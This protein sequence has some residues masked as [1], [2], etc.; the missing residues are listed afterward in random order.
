MGFAKRIMIVEDD[1]ALGKVLTD[2]F[3]KHGYEI[4]LAR[5]SI[6]AHSWLDGRVSIILLDI[7]LPGRKNGL[8]ILEEIRSAEQ[9]YCRMPVIML[10]NQ[11]DRS[12]EEKAYSLGADDFL[13]KSNSSLD[14]IMSVIIEKIEQNIAKVQKDR[15]LFLSSNASRIMDKIVSRLPST[16]DKL[17]MAFIPTGADPYD[18]KP[19]LEQDKTALKKAG[20][21][22]F[23]L[24]LKEKDIPS[25]KESLS[26]IDIIF[27]AGGDV[28]YLMKAIQD[29]GL[30]EIIKFFIRRE[31]III[32]SSAGS[33]VLG[34]SINPYSVFN[35][36]H[37]VKLDNTDG[38]G[39]I[40]FLILPH[41]DNPKYHAYHQQI[42]DKYEDQYELMPLADDQLIVV[43]KGKREIV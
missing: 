33:V 10:T 36:D 42:R 43:E 12:I 4:I 31:T 32:G 8:D 25:L 11:S 23:E 21:K 9:N 7:N 18:E 20:F 6:E 5:N 22:F 1:A 29:S 28:Y 14:Q 2:F 34:P 15:K 30:D 17:N 40:D 13:V 41:T 37:S 24:D 38:L 26:D 27:I 19:W 3:E 39:L 35:D 16:P